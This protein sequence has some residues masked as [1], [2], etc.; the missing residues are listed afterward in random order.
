MKIGRLEITPKRWPWQ[1]GYNWKGMTASSAPFNFGMA[2]F[3]G[4]WRYKLG[5]DIGGTTIILNLLFGLILIRLNKESRN[6]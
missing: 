6:V 2:R 3:G 5:I 4:G 1:D